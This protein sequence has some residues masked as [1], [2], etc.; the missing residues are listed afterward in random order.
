MP[1]ALA[2]QTFFAT[3]RIQTNRHTQR[4]LPGAPNVLYRS[5]E[6]GTFERYSKTEWRRGCLPNFG[7]A[8]FALGGK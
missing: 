4:N 1:Q 8:G 5:S 2:M 3:Y 7:G 6:T